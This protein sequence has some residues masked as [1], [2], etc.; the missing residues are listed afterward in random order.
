MNHNKNE[1][2]LFYNDFSQYYHLIYDNWNESIKKQ[3]QQLDSIIKEFINEEINTVLDVSCGIGT[4]SLGLAEMGYKVTGSDISEKEIKRAQSEAVKRGLEIS[5]Y[6]ADMRNVFE[7]TKKEFDVIISCDNS[8]PH[9]LT[10][11]DILKAF[12][13]FYKSCK[14]NGGC[15]ISVRDY[16]KEIIDGK[17]FKPYGIREF[18]GKLFIISQVWDCHYPRYTT[19]M[20]IVED[21]R[22]D[23]CRTHVMRTEYYAIKIP[24]LIELMQVAG[25]SRVERIDGRFFQPIILGRKV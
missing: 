23:K 4:Q 8:V 1:L 14:L 16:E 12:K 21:N 24:R 18:D 6:V 17:I 2:E 25:F 19:S 11:D 3:S 10:D 15:I 20:Y 5:F 13:Q 9:L 22:H 7:Q